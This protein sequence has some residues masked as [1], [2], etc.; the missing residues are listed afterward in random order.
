MGFLKINL[1][2]FLI[3]VVNIL[4][5]Q[6]PCFTV[7]TADDETSTS[8]DWTNDANWNGTSPGCDISAAN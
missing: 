1:S 5:A 4:I 8:G 6:T 7:G 3:L 2:I